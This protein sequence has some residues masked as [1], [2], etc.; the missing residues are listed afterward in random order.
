MEPEAIQDDEI[1]LHRIP[2]NSE[3]GTYRQERGSGRVTATSFAFKLREGEEGISCTRI[4]QTSPQQLL[5]L[6]PDELDPTGWGVC[7]I[8]VS[9]IR[10][11]G[12]EVVH[13]PTDDDPGH[14]EIRPTPEKPLNSGA[15]S[16][17]AKRTRMLS[18]KEISSGQIEP[19]QEPD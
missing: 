9:E 2:P 13:C 19:T 17:L 4:G 5:D 14:C 3:R 11:L 1:I 12:L 15:A 16:K 7:Q 6:L 10:K 18:E 8:K